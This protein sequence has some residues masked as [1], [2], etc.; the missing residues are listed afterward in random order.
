MFAKYIKESLSA[1]NFTTHHW[2]KEM[3][4][5]KKVRMGDGQKR[6]ERESKRQRGGSE[7]RRRD[8]REMG[9]KIWRTERKE[10]EK[11]REK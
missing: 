10:R 6:R 9:M 3:G 8:Y 7:G 11:Q 5:K 1:V 4:N 2:V